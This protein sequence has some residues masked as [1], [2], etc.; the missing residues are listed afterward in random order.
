[1]CRHGQPQVISKHTVLITNGN[2]QIIDDSR[3]SGLFQAQ[4][5]Q[6]RQLLVVGGATELDQVWGNIFLHY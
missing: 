3:L 5:A 1:M 2:Y 4:L 6:V